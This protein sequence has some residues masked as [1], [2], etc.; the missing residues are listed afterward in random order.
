MCR[1]CVKYGDG[2]KWY[3]NP[4]NYT[5]E[6]IHGETTKERMEETMIGPLTG[7]VGTIQ[8]VMTTAQ[9][10]KWDIGLGENVDLV[11]QDLD[12]DLARTIRQGLPDF[13]DKALG[14]QVVPLED[15]EK[16]ID[17]NEGDILL[18]PC[19]CRKY[20][21]GIEQMCCMFLRPAAK[22]LQK[23][24]SW[25][26][27]SK[28]A[29]KEEVKEV[30]R[31]VDKQGLIHAIFFT[32]APIPTMMCNCDYPYCI[33]LR[34]RLHYNVVDVF[35]KAEYVALIDPSNCNGCG[36]KPNCQV[37]CAFGALKY[38]PTSGKVIVNQMQCWG[39]GL[40]RRSCPNEAIKL[41]PREDISQLKDMW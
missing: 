31:E 35:R 33:A 37:R 2:T 13:I 8:E 14:G 1:H 30:L 22:A 29:S 39:C 23:N 5:D 19:L 4:K 3:L 34:G 7:A 17:L 36:G 28:M 32:P 10:F 26:A 12:D 40:C 15:A 9:R 24:I 41:I 21:G 27:P 16:I 6:V 18:L 25:E 38:S 11:F 20:Y